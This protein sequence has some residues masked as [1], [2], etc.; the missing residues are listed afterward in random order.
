MNPG[1]PALWLLSS[2]KSL[3]ISLGSG[4]QMDQAMPAAWDYCRDER[5]DGT[6]NTKPL[7]IN[8]ELIV[9][10]FAHLLICLIFTTI[11]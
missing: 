6:L 2:S 7:L 9:K 4:F 5:R 8:C 1:C 3:G 10:T 11:L